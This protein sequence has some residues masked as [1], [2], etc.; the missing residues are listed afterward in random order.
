MLS[1]ATKLR[2]VSINPT[3]QSIKVYATTE[4]AATIRN[5]MQLI[6][7]TIK[8]DETLKRTLSNNFDGDYTKTQTFM[9]AFDLFWMINEE[10]A[11]MKTLYK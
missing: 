3:F 10:S 4:T 1:S 6:F 5:A 11:V 2:P 8:L 7:N 9:N